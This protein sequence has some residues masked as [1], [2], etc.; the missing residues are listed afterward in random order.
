MHSYWHPDSSLVPLP[1]STRFRNPHR[2]NRTLNQYTQPDVQGYVSV[3][4]VGILSLDENLDESSDEKLVLSAS[5]YL[6]MKKNAVD[7]MQQQHRR[8][9]HRIWG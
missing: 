2:R 1:N 8:R 4:V 7:R 9:R 6:G 3:S 5:Y